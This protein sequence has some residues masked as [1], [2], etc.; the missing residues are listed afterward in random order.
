MDWRRI[1]YMVIRKIGNASIPLEAGHLTLN[2]HTWHLNN[3]H[4]KWL[5]AH[6]CR[7]SHPSPLGRPSQQLCWFHQCL[8]RFSKCC[9]RVSVC[10]A[11]AHLS[12][13]EPRRCVL[14]GRFAQNFC[15]QSWH[16]LWRQLLN[17]NPN[18]IISLTINRI[19]YETCVHRFHVTCSSPA[20]GIEL[21]MQDVLK[22][23]GLLFLLKMETRT[24]NY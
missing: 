20:P 7:L 1:V 16:R 2:Q 22:Q 17:P 11:T 24:L 12:L 6:A 19:G 13:K 15:H 10:D 3:C 8:A 5:H 9:F 23:S 4:R 18:P 21:S 14:S